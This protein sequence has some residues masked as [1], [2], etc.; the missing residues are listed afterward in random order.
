MYCQKR[1]P[2]LESSTST[3][4]QI[5]TPPHIDGPRDYSDVHDTN[6]FYNTVL[7]TSIAVLTVL[8]CIAMLLLLP[9]FDSQTSIGKNGMGDSTGSG[10]LGENSGHGAGNLPRAKLKR[11]PTTQLPRLNTFPRHPV[12]VFLRSDRGEPFTPAGHYGNIDSNEL[13]APHAHHPDV[14]KL[15]HQSQVPVTYGA[16]PRT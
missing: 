16:S 2:A 5:G 4:E 3:H 11:L 15:G 1:I 13:P 12:A 8:L 14:Q 7:G 9:V 10:G 6:I